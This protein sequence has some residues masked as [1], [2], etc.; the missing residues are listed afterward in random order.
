MITGVSVR[1][2]R[3]I[4][5]KKDRKFNIVVNKG[6]QLIY[7]VLTEAVIP[8]WSLDTLLKEQRQLSCSFYGKYKT[9]KA[10][11]VVLYIYIIRT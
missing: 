3:I 4:L 10:E 9:G 1:S 11:F 7:L 6:L 2:N 8:Y 5:Q